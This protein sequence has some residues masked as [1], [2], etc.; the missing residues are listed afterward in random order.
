LPDRLDD[1]EGFPLLIGLLGILNA[2]VLGIASIGF[3]T[4]P[5]LS[6][7]LARMMG[8]IRL[9]DTLIPLALEIPFRP[10]SLIGLVTTIVMVYC[11]TRPET[12]IH[13]K[14]RGYRPWYRGPFGGWTGR[15]HCRRAHPI[16]NRYINNEMGY[17]H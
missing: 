17:Y 15:R 7:D 6:W 16:G 14:G 8:A 2:V 12:I 4:G 11:L 3:W 10:D 9:A 5:G 1:V 13:F